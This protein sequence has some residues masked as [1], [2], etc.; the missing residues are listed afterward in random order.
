MSDFHCGADKSDEGGNGHSDIFRFDG[1][2]ASRS[3]VGGL[4]FSEGD[5]IR[6][7]DFP[8]GTF[9]HVPGGNDLEVSA[10]GSSVVI[11]SLTDLQELDTLSPALRVRDLGDSGIQITINQPGHDKLVLTFDHMAQDF[12]PYYDNQWF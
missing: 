9:N 1:Q 6:L 3:R 4:D 2:T 7:V 8:R 10:D 12:N 11:D 5:E